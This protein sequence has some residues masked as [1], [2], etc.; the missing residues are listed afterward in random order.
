MKITMILE[1]RRAPSENVFRKRL[2]YEWG[3]R[4]GSYWQIGGDGERLHDHRAVLLIHE[5]DVYET[6]V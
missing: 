1:K 4:Q 2:G 5:D 3:R 6:M